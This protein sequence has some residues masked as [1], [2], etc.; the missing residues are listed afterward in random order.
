[1]TKKSIFIGFTTIGYVGI[2]LKKGLKERGYFAEFYS[3]D[4]TLPLPKKLNFVKFIRL[5]RYKY[6]VKN[7]KLHFVYR[8][9]YELFMCIFFIYTLCKFD[10]FIFIFAQ[11]TFLYNNIDLKILKMLKKKIIV[12]EMGSDVRPPYIDGAFFFKST[13]EKIYKETIKKKKLVEQIEKYADYILSEPSMAVF[14][15]KEFIKISSIGL[16]RIREEYKISNYDNFNTNYIRI[17]HAPSNLEVKGTFFIRSIIDRLKKKFLLK[18]IIIEY[19]ELNGLEHE[20]VIEIMG[21]AD[22]VVDQAY[23][24]IPFSGCAYEAALL[25]KPVVIGGEYSNFIKNDY[26]D[27]EIF[28]SLYIQPQDMEKIIENLILD[29]NKRVY[30]GN[31]AYDFVNSKWEYS[32]VIDNYINIINDNVNK[33]WFYNPD[34]LGYYYGGFAPIIKIKNLIKEL[35][36][37]YG[38][39][40]LQVDDK[41]NIKNEYLS[42][43]K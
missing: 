2:A 42:L 21:T 36:K 8:V 25:K 37:N 3:L 29:N 1:M 17:V 10:A 24:D 19:I 15:K 23:A 32:K 28:P 31:K 20:K 5:Y 38:E 12:I 7:R 18:N 26:K 11:R 9:L 13:L 4:E 35:V 40:S 33:N 16:P 14:H 27:T 39:F 34:K 6:I 41:S 30:Y 22:I 43:L